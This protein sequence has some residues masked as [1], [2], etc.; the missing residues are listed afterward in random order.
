M[1][2]RVAGMLDD[3]WRMADGGYKGNED[4]KMWI[5]KKGKKFLMTF[6]KKK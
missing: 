4:D 2:E 6:I 3:R 5:G 1:L